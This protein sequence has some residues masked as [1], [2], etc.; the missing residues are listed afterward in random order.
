MSAETVERLCFVSFAGN[1]NPSQSVSKSSCTQTAK[2][3]FCIERT[4][5]AIPGNSD[6]YSDCSVTD[7]R[8]KGDDDSDDDEDDVYVCRYFYDVDKK[9]L[10]WY[11]QRL[12]TM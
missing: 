12:V 4:G 8:E 5:K 2:N 7:K 10:V 1:K 6:V 9:S 3:L 11:E